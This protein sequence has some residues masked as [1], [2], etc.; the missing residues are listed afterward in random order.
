[1]TNG[2]ADTAPVS[3]DDLAGFL[4]DNPE[5]DQSDDLPNDDAP[6]D[7][8]DN[9][10]VDANPDDDSGAGPDSDD[11]DADPDADDPDA[12]EA[13]QKQ[14]SQKFKV[15]VKGE[16]GADIE[17]EVDAKELV[18][19]YQRH[20]DYTRKTQELGTR[21][22]EA[23]ELVSRRLDEG[24]TYYMQEAQK[25]HAAIRTLAGLKTDAEMAQLAQTDQAAWVQERARAEAIKGVLA[26]IE[27]GMTHEQQQAQQ[28][29]MQAQQQ[30][31][32]KAWGVLGQQ[33]IDKPKLKTIFEGVGKAYGV[34]ESRFANVTDPKVVLIMRDALAYREL[35]EKAAAVK[36]E[37]KNAPN[38]P[39][40]RQKV[41]QKEQAN[42]RL[43]QKFRSGN[44]GVKDLAAFLMNN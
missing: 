16:D 2:Q 15:T 17:Q 14:T 23:H 38:L 42:K 11:P 3:M 27:Q 37:V 1:M 18:A 24:R 35:K 25:A 6:G 20:A 7:Q 36:K 40:P 26:Q 10:D 39:A 31:F 33:G 12:A 22:R 9:A 34:E 43:N 4:V 19:G 13:A 30:E 29:S 32:Q 28:Q 44:A 8:P 5:A 41:P 21:E